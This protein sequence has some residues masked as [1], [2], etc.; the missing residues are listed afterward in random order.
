ME[1][2]GNCMGSRLMSRIIE[3]NNNF[4]SYLCHTFTTK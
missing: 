4:G 3:Q 1:K 2:A